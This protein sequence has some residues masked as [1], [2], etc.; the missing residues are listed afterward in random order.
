MNPSEYLREFLKVEQATIPRFSLGQCIICKWMSEE[1]GISH[2][3]TGI[4]VG[5]FHLPDHPYRYQ[6]GWRYW[7]KWERLSVETVPLPHYEEV[8]DDDEF[9][10]I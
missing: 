5:L 1:S 2:N 4:I 10:P 9:Q 7:V 3:D 6:K 8:E